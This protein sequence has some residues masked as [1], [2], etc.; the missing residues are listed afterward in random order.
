[1]T[2]SRDSLGGQNSLGRQNGARS[3]RALST[4]F[5]RLQKLDRE[6]GLIRQRASTLR[7]LMVFD[8][9]RK[10]VAALKERHAK[11]DA[12]RREVRHQRKAYARPLSTRS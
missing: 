12:E 7:S 10:E 4:I 3:S 2:L 8:H 9:V 6:I 11:L 1:M 5:K